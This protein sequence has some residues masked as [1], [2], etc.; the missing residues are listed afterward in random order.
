MLYIFGLVRLRE[1][2]KAKKIALTHE[3]PSD[4]QLPGRAL[5]A[6]EVL[7]LNTEQKIRVPQ[8]NTEY[9]HTKGGG[10]SIICEI[11]EPNRWT[12]SWGELVRSFPTREF[13]TQEACLYVR[14]RMPM[15]THPHTLQIQNLPLKTY[16]CSIFE[17]KCILAHW[18]HGELIFLPLLTRNSITDHCRLK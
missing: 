15:H 11:P 8:E 9:R 16:A 1:E 7:E 6:T 10:F 5:E 12:W 17:Q 4:S 18:K 2:W 3:V 14:T 13:V